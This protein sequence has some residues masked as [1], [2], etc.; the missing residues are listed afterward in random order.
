MNFTDRDLLNKY[1]V[2]TQDIL[3]PALKSQIQKDKNFAI[4]YIE[5]IV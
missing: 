2:I 5:K 3:I 4:S 1:L